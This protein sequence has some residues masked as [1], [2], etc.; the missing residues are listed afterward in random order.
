METGVL[1]VLFH[2]MEEQIVLFVNYLHKQDK[3]L[4]G[5]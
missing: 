4:Y 1:L 5:N 3:P 2:V